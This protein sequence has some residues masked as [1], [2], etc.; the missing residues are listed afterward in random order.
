MTA[1]W[2]D[3]YVA[4]SGISVIHFLPGGSLTGSSAGAT[5]TA[6]YA[7]VGLGPVGELYEAVLALA[8]AVMMLS[9][10]GGTLAVISSLGSSRTPNRIGTIR[11]LLIAVLII[12]LLTV[13]LVPGIQPYALSHSSGGCS[14]FGSQSPCKSFWGNGTSSGTQYAW[15]G[16]VGYYLMVAAT[17]FAVASFIGWIRTRS[18][19]RGPAPTHLLGEGNVAGSTRGVHPASPVEN[20]PPPSLGG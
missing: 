8:L 19:P 1:W 14:G 5:L 6:P 4:G 7:L 2:A 10:I 16:D 3:S 17:L 18:E 11:V 12:G 9:L 15:A 20:T 13:V